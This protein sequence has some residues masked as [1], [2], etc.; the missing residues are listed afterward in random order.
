MLNTTP[1]N[2]CSGS[3]HQN[4]LRRL[5]GFSSD[6]DAVVQRGGSSFR[7]GNGSVR[8]REL[9]L[10]T[11]GRIMHTVTIIH[12][13]STSLLTSKLTAPRLTH[14]YNPFS[15][16]SVVQPTKP[17]NEDTAL[18][19]HPGSGSDSSSDLLRYRVLV[20]CRTRRRMFRVVDGFLCGLYWIKVLSL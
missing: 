14:L 15:P 6:H 5:A 16:K 18:P 2:L 19:R 11:L 17:N 9:L 10:L 13:I 20:S 7:E 3:S 8:L 1:E 12:P 4:C